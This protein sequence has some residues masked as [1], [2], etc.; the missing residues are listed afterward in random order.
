MI[1]LIED[2]RKAKQRGEDTRQNQKGHIPYVSL[3]LQCEGVVMFC[4]TYL[5]LVTCDCFLILQ[6]RTVQQIKERG[7]CKKIINTDNYCLDVSVPSGETSVADFLDF[8]AL[9]IILELL[10]VVV[11]ISNPCNV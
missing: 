2:K 3:L 10:Y 5:W 4:F 8:I 11:L 6:L 9:K 7:P 1:S